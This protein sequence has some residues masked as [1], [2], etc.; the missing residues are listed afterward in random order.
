VAVFR[1]KEKKGGGPFAVV[2]LPWPSP[3]LA[4]RATTAWA[5]GEAE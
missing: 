1:V 5:K 4:L 2:V 3:C